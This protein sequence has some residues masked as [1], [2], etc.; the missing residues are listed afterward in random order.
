MTQ[1][2]FVTDSVTAVATSIGTGIAMVPAH[3]LTPIHTI[4]VPLI[5]G[6]LAPLIK[7]LIISLRENRKRKR[8]EKNKKD[9]SSC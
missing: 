1:T 8:E 5:T 7:E 2:N 9:D 6:L 3:D 4:Y